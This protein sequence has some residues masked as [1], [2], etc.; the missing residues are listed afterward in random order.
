VAILRSVFLKGTSTVQLLDPLAALA[1]I[2]LV[3]SVLAA[4]AFHKRLV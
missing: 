4:R 1:F 3:L 2:A